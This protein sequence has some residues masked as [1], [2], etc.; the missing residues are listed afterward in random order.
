MWSQCSEGEQYVG[1]SRFYVF[2]ARFS[3]QVES[4]FLILNCDGPSRENDQNIRANLSPMLNTVNVALWKRGWLLSK[5][6]Y[7]LN[8]R[9][10]CLHFPTHFMPHSVSF[11]VKIQFT[12][13]NLWDYLK[14][15]FVL[16]EYVGLYIVHYFSFLT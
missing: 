6:V 9:S 12:L 10:L 2:V 3:I 4:L 8:N 7:P 13:N 16:L 5:I 11:C 1:F 14:Y 15:H